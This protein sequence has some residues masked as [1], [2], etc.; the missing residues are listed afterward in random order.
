[1]S[2]LQRHKIPKTAYN[3]AHFT[4]PNTINTT[5]PANMPPSQNP[6][7][8]Y[9]PPA[10]SGPS[11]PKL[12]TPFT[13]SQSN[14]NGTTTTLPPPTITRQGPPPASSM[15]A[16]G[17]QPHDQT[18]KPTL[19]K[20]SRHSDRRPSNASTSSFYTAPLASQSQVNSAVYDSDGTGTGSLPTHHISDGGTFQAPRPPANVQ[21]SR[22]VAYMASLAPDISPQA[23]TAIRRTVAGV[24]LMGTGLTVGGFIQS[25]K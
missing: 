16:T 6:T 3:T 13:P 9:P 23:R 10:R 1:M 15:F 5:H 25:N 19:K 12:P 18:N 22:P 7:V 17:S 2:K 14:T 8:T 24:G 21:P 20:K 11:H 4:N